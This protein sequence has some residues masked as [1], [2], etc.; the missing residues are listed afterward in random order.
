MLLLQLFGLAGLETTG[1]VLGFWT[2]VVCIGSTWG[3][4]GVLMATALAK[5]FRG[6]N[7]GTI[8]GMA[9]AL[10]SVSGAIGVPLMSFSRG[11]L[12]SYFHATHFL[13]CISFCTLFFVLRKFRWTAS[14]P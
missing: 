3:G 9:H 7:L 6:K 4:Y 12:G 11:N 2:Y 5:V 10:A 8:L 1:S 13:G 14:K